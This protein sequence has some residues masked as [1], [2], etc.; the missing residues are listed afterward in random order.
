MVKKFQ[1]AA[2]FGALMFVA[3]SCS[4]ENE[5]SFDVEPVSE[6]VVYNNI[7]GDETSIEDIIVSAED[8]F[9]KTGLKNVSGNPYYYDIKVKHSKT[10]NFPDEIFEN[11]KTWKKMDCDLNSGAGGEWIYL[12]VRV[13]KSFLDEPIRSFV[14]VA[15]NKSHTYSSLKSFVDKNCNG[16]WVPVGETDYAQP[17]DLNAGAGGKWVY[18]AA[19][20][21]QT[22]WDKPITD[23]K[24]ISTANDYTYKS[25]MKFENDPRTYRPVISCSNINNNLGR[26]IYGLAFDFN[27]D[28]KKHNKNVYIFYTRE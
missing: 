24:V 14:G 2:L 16:Y 28:T 7:K 1:F 15:S 4:N 17:F 25:T 12:Y 26:N 19:S 23:F 22:V 10:Y 8:L 13:N 9:K 20:Y 6:K 3:P 5:E 27:T 11:G 21:D 18:L